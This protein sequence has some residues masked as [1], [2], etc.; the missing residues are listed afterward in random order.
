[1]EQCRNEQISYWCGSFSSLSWT[2]INSYRKITSKA[3]KDSQVAG[4]LRTWKQPQVPERGLE[5]LPRRALF[6]VVV[7]SVEKVSKHSLVC[8]DVRHLDTVNALGAGLRQRQARPSIWTTL[9]VFDAPEV[10]AVSFRAS[11]S[12]SP[13]LQLLCLQVLFLFIVWGNCCNQIA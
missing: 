4:S 12:F 1:M 8:R 3:M 9:V 11:V 13:M 7:V 10:T 2:I 5:D 6:G